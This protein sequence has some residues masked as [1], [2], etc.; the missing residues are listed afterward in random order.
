MNLPSSDIAYLNERGIAHEVALESGMTCILFPQW[1][2]PSGFDRAAAD[3]LVRL[4]PGYPDVSPDM[5]WFSPAVHLVNGEALPAT[6]VVEIH[7]GR[8]WQRWSRH[9][10]SGQ[11][12]SGVDGLGSFLTLIRQNL[13]NSVPEMVR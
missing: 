6:N 4:S 10:H 13:E 5:W 7:L 1:P 8:R 9:F 3:L 12:Q 11:W 2:L